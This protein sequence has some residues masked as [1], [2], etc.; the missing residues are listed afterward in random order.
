MRKVRKT[1]LPEVNN[2]NRKTKGC[3]VYLLNVLSRVYLGG[4]L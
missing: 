3:K 4:C 2:D 1:T